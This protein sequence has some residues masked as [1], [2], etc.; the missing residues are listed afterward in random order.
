MEAGGTEQQVK[1]TVSVATKDIS[2]FTFAE[3]P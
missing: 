3:H 1:R 2:M